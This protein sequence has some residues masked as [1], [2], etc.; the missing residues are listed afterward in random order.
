M[1][2]VAVGLVLV[3]AVPSTQQSSAAPAVKTCDRA[4]AE[5]VTGAYQQVYLAGAQSADPPS[6]GQYQSYLQ[7]SIPRGAVQ[8]LYYKNRQLLLRAFVVRH[9]P[10]YPKA[11]G[12]VGGFFETDGQAATLGSAAIAAVL[13]HLRAASVRMILSVVCESGVWKVPLDDFC[14]AL[15]ASPHAQQCS[16]AL[17]RKAKKG[18][19]RSFTN[20]RT[21]PPTIVTVPTTSRTPSTNSPNQV[22][23]TRP[24]FPGDPCNPQDTPPPGYVCK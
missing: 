12:E 7:F 23:T 20:A 8:R 5:D 21:A 3:T 16:K 9:A 6:S 14:R 13:Y 19:P 18:L 22:P 17:L 2:A 15:N 24:P 1:V 11:K 10:N 4:T